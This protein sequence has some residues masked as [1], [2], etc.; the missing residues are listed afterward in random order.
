MTP[1]FW[2]VV[3]V[4]HAKPI[5]GSWVQ[6]VQ[7]VSSQLT[8]KLSWFKSIVLQVLQ[9]QSNQKRHISW[10][11]LLKCLLYICEWNIFLCWTYLLPIKKTINKNMKLIVSYIPKAPWASTGSHLQRFTRIVVIWSRGCDTSPSNRSDALTLL[12]LTPA[13]WEW[14][15]SQLLTVTVVLLQRAAIGCDRSP[16]LISHQASAFGPTAGRI[17]GP[18]R[19]TESPRPIITN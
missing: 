11:E 5:S 16:S 7:G 8:A 4:F 17:S 3:Y 2:T 1:N 14:K 10:F 13:E 12:I 6:F 9:N 18:P 15:F 19:P